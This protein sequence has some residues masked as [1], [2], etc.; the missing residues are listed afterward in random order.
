MVTKTVKL[1]ELLKLEPLVNVDLKGIRD[2]KCHMTFSPDEAT[3]LELAFD[4]VSTSLL[5][6]KVA[7]IRVILEEE[8]ALTALV[9]KKLT[10]QDVTV[11]E[12]QWVESPVQ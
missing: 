6:Q 11:T 1:A 4:D 8:L 10:L 2:G 5:K 7:A 3:I 9:T 12:K